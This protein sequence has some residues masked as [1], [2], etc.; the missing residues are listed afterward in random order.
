MFYLFRSIDL[1][2]I[3]QRASSSILATNYFGATKTYSEQLITLGIHCK[4]SKAS[5]SIIFP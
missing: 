2:F 1:I 5:T 4:I 3:Q